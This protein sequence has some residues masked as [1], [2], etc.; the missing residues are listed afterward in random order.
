MNEETPAPEVVEEPAPTPTP[1]P[2]PDPQAEAAEPVKEELI[3]RKRLDKIVW[4]REEEKRRGDYWEAE[5]KKLKAPKETTPEA[6]DPGK[7]NVNDP[8]WKSYDEFTEA[9]A[10]WKVE[11]RI[12]KAHQEFSQRTANERRQESLNTF[13]ERSEKVKEKYPDYD[14]LFEDATIS[15][16]MA[17]PIMESESG[18]EIVVYLAKNPEVAKTL[19]KMSPI[20]AAREIGKIEAKLDDLLQTKIITDAKPPLKPVRPKGEVTTGLDDNLDIKTWMRNRNKQ[21]GR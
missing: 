13:K 16:A 1:D 12:Q 17:E 10:E 2:S 15:E 5:A 21:L 7:P 6:V 9:L 18:P 19:S 4:Q 3:P 20:A 8:K 14:E 11:Q